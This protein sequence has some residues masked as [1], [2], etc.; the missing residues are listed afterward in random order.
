MQTQEWGKSFTTPPQ[1]YW[2]ASVEFPEYEQLTGDL[3]VDA[4]IVGGGIAGIT[5]AFLLKQSG[6][7]VALL[8]AT[9]ILHGTTG[10]TTAKVTAQHDIIYNVIKSKMNQESAEQYANANKAAITAIDTIIQQNN[11]ECDFSW[12]P[13]YVYTQ[14]DNYI[15][16]VQDEYETALSL[17]LPAVYMDEIPLPF[18]VK[19]ALRFDSQAQFHPIKYLLALAALIPG[20][21]SYLF[22]NTKAI[23]IH[24][25]PSYRISTNTG[26]SVNAPNV[27]IATHYPF[28][29][30]NGMYF[31]RIYPDRS[32]ALGITISDK[33]P[34]GMYITAEDPGR[35]WRSQ[36]LGNGEELIIVGGEHHKTGQ[37]EDTSIHYENLLETANNTFQVKE[38][39]YRWSTQDYTTMDKVPYIGPL[40]SK[41]PGIYVAT[42]FRK[43]GMTNGTAA[44]MILRD[45][46][47]GKENEWAPAF[48]PSRFK[49]GASV[50]KLVKENVDVAKHL[51]KGKL[52]AAANNV[53]IRPGEAKVVEIDGAKRGAY[54][55]MRGQLHIV[56]TTCTHLGCELQWN[57]AEHSWDCPCH[58]SRF[59]YEGEIIEGPAQK[60]L[61]KLEVNDSLKDSM[62]NKK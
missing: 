24:T 44:A 20:N 13:A 38:V 56:D 6:L 19:A 41:D 22:E 48:V 55:D 8:E 37:G 43:W 16:Q 32:Y 61:N 29:D 3:D 52:T 50:G 9:R 28:Y 1:S 40:N 58:G 62:E 34:G 35:S 17:G 12:Q 11:I 31:A 7:K 21:G 60:P 10:H 4:V 18:K 51:I 26:F 27:I 14:D 36:P 49:P 15:L 23:D 25:Q 39:L 54:R 59:T 47:L 45:Y 46:I 57:S 33:Y 30:G 5:S 53:D 2:M 42:G